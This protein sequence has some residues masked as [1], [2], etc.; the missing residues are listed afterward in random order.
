MIFRNGDH[1][2]YDEKGIHREDIK[3]KIVAIANNNMD[4]I[5][6]YLAQ[7]DSGTY[8]QFTNHNFK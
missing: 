5:V 7:L 4:M 1:V 2:I 8:I 3:G 6:T